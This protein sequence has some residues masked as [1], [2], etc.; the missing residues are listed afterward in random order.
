MCND[1]FIKEPLNT[2][3]SSAEILNNASTT[4]SD[5]KYPAISEFPPPLSVCTVKNNLNLMK[6]NNYEYFDEENDFDEDKELFRKRT[7][8]LNLINEEKSNE[9][10]CFILNNFLEKFLNYKTNTFEDLVDKLASINLTS[11]SNKKDNFFFCGDKKKNK[12]LVSM[13]V[14]NLL[15]KWFNK[16]ELPVI[17]R[18]FS[19]SDINFNNFKCVFFCVHYLSENNE[20][21]SDFKLSKFH[22]LVNTTD[23]PYVIKISRFFSYFDFM[24]LIMKKFLKQEKKSI[25]D[26]RVWLIDSDKIEKFNL[27]INFNDFL[28]NIS[29]KRLIYNDFYNNLI[30]S[31]NFSLN[32]KHHI[33]IETKSDNNFNLFM[34]EKNVCLGRLN[35]NPFIS[36]HIGLSNLGNTC[37]INSALQCLIHIYD[38]SYYFYNNDYKYDINVNNPLSY[39]GNIAYAYDCLL[40]DY[41]DLS[42]K[43]LYISPRN[44]CYTIGKYLHTFSDYLQHDSHEFFSWFLDAL[45]EDLN[46]VNVNSLRNQPHSNVFNNC[47]DDE[48]LMNLAKLTWDQH[49]LRNDSI[50]SDMFTGLYKS[51]LRC[52]TCKNKSV[53]FDPFNDLTLPI[54]TPNKWFNIRFVNFFQTCDFDK[55]NVNNFDIELDTNYTFEDLKKYLSKFL[56]IQENHLYI[57]ELFDSMVYRDF[58][59]EYDKIEFLPISEI[60]ENFDNICVYYIPKDNENDLIIPFFNYTDFADEF[61]DISKFFELPFFIVFNQNDLTNY[62]SIKK[63]I[64]DWINKLFFPFNN[65]NLDL[66]GSGT[67]DHNTT[68]EKT[69]KQKDLNNMNTPLNKSLIESQKDTDLPDYTIKFLFLDEKLKSKKDIVCLKKNKTRK[70]INNNVLPPYDKLKINDFQNFDESFNKFAEF[71]NEKDS[72][73]LF[74]FENQSI[75]KKMK[76]EDLDNHDFHS[77]KKNKLGNKTN[78][79]FNLK[80]SSKNE[81]F[82]TDSNSD[83]SITHNHTNV[84]HCDDINPNFTSIAQNLKKLFL[85]K[86]VLFLICWSKNDFNDFFSKDFKFSPFGI[87]SKSISKSISYVKNKVR[88]SVTLDKCFEMFSRTEILNDA[89]PWY[90]PNCKSY[91]QAS[92]RIQIWFTSDILIIHLKRFL[93]N[94]ASSTKLNTL[95][96][97][98]FYDLNI[99]NYVVN[100]S[101]KNDVYD[102]FAINNHY[103][104]LSSGHYTAYVKNTKSNIW[105]Q[106]NDAKCSQVTDIQSCVS[107]SAYLLF[108]RK[109]SANE[110]MNQFKNETSCLF[111]PNSVEV[112][113]HIIS[114]NNKNIDDLHYEIENFKKNSLKEKKDRSNSVDLSLHKTSKQNDYFF[115]NLSDSKL[116][117]FFSNDLNDSKSSVLDINT[118]DKIDSNNN[119]RKQR[120]ISR[121]NNNNVLVQIK[122]NGK[123]FLNFNKSNK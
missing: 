73:Q 45:H 47:D 70:S 101:K 27:T 109:R 49:K 72:N 81:D 5:S 43:K 114:P 87:L 1:T 14:F 120:L 76:L 38:L 31:K 46:R 23:K 93:N 42:Y 8:I 84:E 41:V 37:Y 6:F 63:K 40:K 100:P 94:H 79:S 105:Y 74:L 78:N 111:E 32:D 115:P 4:S 35:S 98:P 57:I 83:L 116:N 24:D 58:Q 50:I 103:G 39:G 112:N 64:T 119:I 71:L 54:S 96:T 61:D 121:Q 117:F 108:Y 17:N 67:K 53:T 91:K 85:K 62:E 60:I 68:S 102:L 106:H 110:K 82:K 16:K 36:L 2:S 89:D 9:K 77:L 34:I 25:D 122:N 118:N 18:R 52:P 86:K 95:V 21:D 56:K 3:V 15:S 99:S 19:E 75:S 44:F 92:K 113:D 11:T 7:L 10:N 12:C 107:S 90:C 66:N 29:Y 69:K 30:S 55:K 97:F 13:R 33:L 28:N 65:E 20:L 80:C 123:E 22:E 88:K 51:T 104:S 48:S 59:A 26:F